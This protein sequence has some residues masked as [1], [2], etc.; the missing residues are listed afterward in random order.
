VGVFGVGSVAL[1]E[2]DVEVGRELVADLPGEGQ[3]FDVVGA[4]IFKSV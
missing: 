1:V 3:N 4:D 2:R